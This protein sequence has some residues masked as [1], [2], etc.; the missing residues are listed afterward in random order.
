MMEID[1]KER[2]VEQACSMF[3]RYGIRA[4]T[5][6]AL[7]SQM[8]ISKRTIYE[9]FSDKDELVASVMTWMGHVNMGKINGLMNESET[10]IHAAFKIIEYVGGMMQELNPVLFEDLRKY[11]HFADQQT[12]KMKI[13]D[14]LSL[15]LPQVKKGMDDGFFRKDINADI[16]NRAIHSIFGMTG[17]FE[18]FP[19][20]LF[21]R[22]EIVRNVFVN[23]LR[24]IATTTGIEL[25]DKCE[26][27][28]YIKNR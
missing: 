16:V 13:K 1:I 20:E 24:G 8:G 25:I 11:H 22:E 15:S 27:E 17:D 26:L 4:V 10:V 7:A 9:N 21:R 19:R 14:N 5:M 18:H 6:D 12:M 28:T 2:I 23:F 3:K